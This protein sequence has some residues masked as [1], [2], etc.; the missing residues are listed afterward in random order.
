M[1]VLLFENLPTT[2]L[3]VAIKLGYLSCDELVKGKSL[4]AVNISLATTVLQVVS[5]LI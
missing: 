2:T 5:T 3:L 1:T 4:Q